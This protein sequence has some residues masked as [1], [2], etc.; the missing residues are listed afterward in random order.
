MQGEDYVH[1]ILP[2]CRC[3]LTACQPTC[4]SKGACIACVH[5]AG[6]RKTSMPHQTG[7][8]R[9]AACRLAPRSCL[10]MTTVCAMERSTSAR[11]REFGSDLTSFS[12]PRTLNN[13]QVLVPQNRG[14]MP[15]A[16]CAYCHI[17][18][19]VVV[20]TGIAWLKPNSPG[21]I[22]ALQI[23][24]VFAESPHNL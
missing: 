21:M 23:K 18:H 22:T 1:T 8:T 2:T 16:H 14:G 13:I 19:V 15:L 9:H 7:R 12:L 10:P 17:A 20:H 3:A 6:C 24:H 11:G 5:R 4:W